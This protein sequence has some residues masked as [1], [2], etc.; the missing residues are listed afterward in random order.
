[1]NLNTSVNKTYTVSVYATTPTRG[2]M[3]D[4]ITPRQTWLHEVTAFESEAA[5]K[6]FVSR[7]WPKG[8]MA[9]LTRPDGREWICGDIWL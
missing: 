8:R 2:I 3:A 9:A 6:A 7:P 5:A 1:M 4:V